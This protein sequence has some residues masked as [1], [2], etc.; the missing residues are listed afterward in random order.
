VEDD[1]L[2]QH[3]E[4]PAGSGNSSIYLILFLN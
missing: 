1:D 4:Y 2:E 3:P